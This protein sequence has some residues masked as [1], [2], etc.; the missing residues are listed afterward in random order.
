[1]DDQVAVDR[2]PTL[3]REPIDDL[4]EEPTAVEPAPFWVG[5]GI[6]LADIPEAR[7]SKEGI[8]QGVEHDIGIRVPD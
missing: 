6:V 1:V 7:R 2:T 3:L 8:G 5:V 4:G